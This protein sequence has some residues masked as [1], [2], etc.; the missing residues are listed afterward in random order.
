MNLLFIRSLN[1][2]S[3]EDEKDRKR[4]TDRTC[5]IAQSPP[6]TDA[7]ASPRPAC[8]VPSPFRIANVRQTWTLSQPRLTSPRLLPDSFSQNPSLQL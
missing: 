6:P 3:N 8:S 2:E 5:A 1:F 7:I 4:K